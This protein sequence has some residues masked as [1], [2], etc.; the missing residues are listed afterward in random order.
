M[1]R[2]IK[3][4]VCGQDWLLLQP[5]RES[6]AGR[7]DNKLVTNLMRCCSDISVMTIFLLTMRREKFYENVHA[8]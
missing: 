6:V 1:Q 3:A 2:N 7:L 8:V 5:K 4:I